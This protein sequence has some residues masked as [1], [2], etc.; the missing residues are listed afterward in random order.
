MN[1]KFSAEEYSRYAKVIR[2]KQ[3]RILLEDVMAIDFNDPAMKMIALQ[4]D[5]MADDIA[6]MKDALKSLTKAVQAIAVI[7]QKLAENYAA[8][9]R[10]HSRVDDHEIR[11][12]KMETQLASN[13]WVERIVFFVVTIGIAAWAK[14]VF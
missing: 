7:E 4:Q 6:E 10:A 8:I 9:G 13:Q 14:G 2:R 1:A 3:E 12:R 11:V 5:R